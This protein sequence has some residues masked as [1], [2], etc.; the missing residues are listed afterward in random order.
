[1]AFQREK[2]N[3]RPLYLF[4]MCDSSG[5][6]QGPKINALNT[7]IKE[8]IPEMRRVA[9]DNPFASLLVRAI[10]FS[11][12]ARWLSNEAIPIDE[13]EWT[14]L[15]ADNQTDMGIAFRMVADALKIPPMPKSAY[16]PVLVLVT[17]G[18]PTDP[19]YKKNLTDLKRT[20]WGEKAVRIA[21]GIGEDCDLDVLRD[22]MSGMRIAPLEARNASAIVNYINW[23]TTTVIKEVSQPS[24]KPGVKVHKENEESVSMWTPQPPAPGT[25]PDEF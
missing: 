14:D 18:Q 10:E 21:I 22:F 11:D 9:G 4:L 1:M 6:M 16:P 8:A 17:D 3:A 13:F 25:D 7:A 15:K 20:V 12:G 2:Q 19:D 24:S 5:S 23:A